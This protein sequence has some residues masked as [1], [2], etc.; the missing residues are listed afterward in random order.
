M[1]KIFFYCG[2]LEKRH[3]KT[4]GGDQLMSPQNMRIVSAYPPNMTKFIS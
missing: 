2:P 4:C 1:K 3:I